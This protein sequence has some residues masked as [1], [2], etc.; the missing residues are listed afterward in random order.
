MNAIPTH[1]LSVVIPLF[2]KATT[3]RRALASVLTQT[4]SNFEVVVVNDGSTDD[5]ADIVRATADARVRVL[6]QPN[7]GVSSAR[8]RGIAETRSRLIALLDADDEWMPEHLSDILRLHREFPDC[9]VFGTSYMIGGE[10][11]SLRPLRLKGIQPGRQ[12]VLSNYFELAARSDP[13]LW[14]SA[15]AFSRDAIDAVGGFPEDISQGEDL[16][17]W[18]RLAA[19]YSIAYSNAPSAIFWQDATSAKR[20]VPLRIP[21]DNDAVGKKLRLLAEEAPLSIAPSIRRYIGLWHKMRASMFLRLNARNSAQ[22]ETLQAIRACP[23]WW[24]LYGYLL[25]LTLPR[26]LRLKLMARRVSA[27]RPA[28][29]HALCPERVAWVNPSFLDYRVPVY[30]RLNALTDDSLKIVFSGTRTPPHVANS[31]C[32]VLGVRAIALQGEKFLRFGKLDDRANSHVSIPFQP[33]LLRTL[34]RIQADVFIAEGFFQ[35]TPAVVVMAFL[36]RAALVISYERTCHTERNCPAWRRAYRRWIVRQADALLCNGMLSRDYLLTLGAAADRIFTG[37]MAADSET[38]RRKA[39]GVSANEKAAERSRLRLVTPVF[40]TCGRLIPIKGMMELLAAWK[41]YK[42]GGAS[43]SLLVVGDGEQRD[44]MLRNISEAQLPDVHLAGA[45]PYDQMPRYYR[46][47]DVFVSCTLED[48]WS[49]V[50]PEAMAC[51]LPIACSE[52]NGGWPELISEEQ[53][54]IVFD[55]LD[56]ED[57]VSALKYFADRRDRLIAMGQTSR[58][59]EARFSPDHAAETAMRACRKAIEVHGSRSRQ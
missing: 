3:V 14:T 39:D 30:S 24:K 29:T 15:T 19:R 47:A 43:G 51:A 36:R 54:G 52:Y 44:S 25:L 13:P 33:G 55:P 59:I 2:N 46:L 4:Y 1:F 56:T 31:L 35:W 23:Q 10:G 42:D 32:Q 21:D 17:T 50:V 9:R 20:D 6:N 11:L 28:T 58:E 22:K 48:N 26:T 53:N 57:F 34:S 27:S 37:G 38:L 12:C 7:S 16:L 45:I 49:L 18:A 41:N 40:M 8:N 5:G